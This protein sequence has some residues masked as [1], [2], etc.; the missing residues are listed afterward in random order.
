MTRQ[1][2]LNALNQAARTYSHIEHIN[3]FGGEPTLNGDI[4]EVV[5]EYARYL[6]AQG[7]LKNL[8]TFGITTNGY[9]LDDRMLEILKGYAFSVTLSL[10]GPKQIHDLKRPTKAG[11]GSYEA[12]AANAKRL[13]DHGL[14]VEFECTYTADHLRLGLTIVSLMSFF[15]EEFGCRTLHCPIVSAAPDSPEFIPF[16][17]CL[18]LQGDAIER[19]ILNLA[20]GIPST[21]SIAVR[22]LNSLIRQTPIWNYCP[23]GRSEVTINADGNIYACFM[24]MQ[25]AA[26]SFGSVNKPATP[27]G[28][29][30][31]TILGQSDGLG[32]RKG[33]IEGF[34]EDANKYTND[35][36]TKC[37]AQPL[38]H[39]CLGEDF[40]RHKKHV[41]RS[42]I[43]G[44]SAFCDYKRG[45]VERTLRAITS[46]YRVASQQPAGSSVVVTS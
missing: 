32:V 20:R 26:Y 38:C 17:T 36:C 37:W 35:A 31:F 21:V 14:N 9:V 33:L 12:V 46:A 10:D 15:A 5:C 16:D 3:F 7:L 27:A 23:A 4:I 40:E 34:I 30:H 18:E 42:E 39:G 25:N 41:L 19:S 45:L 13:L 29:G 44:V 24:L 2:A 28:G 22:I 8:P 1:T 43:P 11:K 6:H